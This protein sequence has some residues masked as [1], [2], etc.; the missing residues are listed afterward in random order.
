MAGQ[1]EDLQLAERL[2][3]H[4]VLKLP[5]DSSVGDVGPPGELGPLPGKKAPPDMKAD[6]R[7]PILRRHNRYPTRGKV[8]LIGT[9]LKCRHRFLRIP[10]DFFV[11]ALRS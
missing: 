7:R 1:A 11:G 4:L 2:L 10:V 5:R 6:L 8:S 3:L 9:G